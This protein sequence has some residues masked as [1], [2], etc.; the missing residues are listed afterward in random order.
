V[1]K[2]HEYDVAPVDALASKVT[3]NPLIK[4]E[5]RATGMEEATLV[6]IGEPTNDWRY[7]IWASLKPRSTFSDTVVLM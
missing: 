1:P 5:N 4:Y 2:F 6:L 3:V 7:V